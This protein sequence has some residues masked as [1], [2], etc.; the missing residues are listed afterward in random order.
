MLSSSV[1]G[2]AGPYFFSVGRLFLSTTASLPRKVS[3]PTLPIIVRSG[4]NLNLSISALTI[5]EMTFWRHVRLRLWWH[6]LCGLAHHHLLLEEALQRELRLVVLD[7]WSRLPDV[8]DEALEGKA[9]PADL[10]EHFGRVD[11]LKGVVRRRED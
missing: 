2:F 11:H 5:G 9:Q 4:F 10:P 6:H 1:Y 8:A 7:L 3:S